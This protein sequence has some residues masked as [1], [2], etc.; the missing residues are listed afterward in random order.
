M[1]IARKKHAVSDILD[2]LRASVALGQPTETATD[3]L[4]DLSAVIGGLVDEHAGLADELLAVY[5]QLG[6]V[7]EVARK[8]PS[9]QNETEV[10]ELFIGSLRQS[11]QR[12]LVFC[13]PADSMD[14]EAVPA[15][16][17]NRAWLTE[18]VDRT[19]RDHVVLV[20]S[21]PAGSMPRAI[22]EV[23]VGP[24]FAGETFVCAIVLARGKEGTAFRA[25]DMLLLEALTMFCGD[26]I[27]NRR[28]ML[29]LQQASFTVVRALVNAVDQKDVY[30]SGHSLRVG[31]FA[32]LLGARLGLTDRE[33]EMLKWAAL[34][35][36]VGKIGIR[37]DVLKK[38]GKLTDDEF[39]HMKEHPSRSYHVASQVPQ[40]SGA[41]G[42]VLHHHERFDG[43]GYPNGLVGEAI[44]L[45]ARIIIIADIF[46]ALTSDRAYRKAFDWQ[47]ALSILEEESGKTVDP[48][49]LAVFR[50]DASRA[51]RGGS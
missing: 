44:P 2:R 14:Q 22:E 5:E 6:V 18:M 11:F 8:L 13:I 50:H 12:H 38:A 19:I 21:P 45:Q 33:L 47:K 49:L 20:E 29:E 48:T 10:T 46:D 17:R 16:L 39:A 24:V 27:R 32:T 34:L 42:G 26:L 41:L 28:L 36:D 25:S 9:V 43:S 15:D 31:Y 37:D 35:H 40:L 23:M 7:F 30:T 51:A 4:D 1:A 3:A